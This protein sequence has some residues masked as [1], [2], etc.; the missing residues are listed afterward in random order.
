METKVWRE[1]SKPAEYSRS[2][3]SKYKVKE[4]RCSQET[5]GSTADPTQKCTAPSPSFPK[6]SLGDQKHQLGSPGHRAEV[7]AL[8]PQEESGYNYLPQEKED[9]QRALIADIKKKKGMPTRREK[10][11]G[12]TQVVAALCKQNSRH[13]PGNS[14][15]MV[16]TATVT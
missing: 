3:A 9:Q 10:G 16:P 1:L 7:P 11:E 5:R 4:S 6:I 13:K 12:E 15:V 2:T 14:K 8:T